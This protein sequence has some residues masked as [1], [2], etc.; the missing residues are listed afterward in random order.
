MKR[1]SELR[2]KKMLET[3]GMTPQGYAQKALWSQMVIQ[4][5]RCESCAETTKCDAALKKGDITEAGD[6]CPN[7][8]DLVRHSP[9]RKN[10]ECMN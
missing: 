9:L 1:A 4:L 8:N 2:I 10:F 3:L 6:F 7:F 5:N